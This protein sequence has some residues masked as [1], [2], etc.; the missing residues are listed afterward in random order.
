M[1]LLIDDLQNIDVATATKML[2]GWQ[3]ISTINGQRISGR[4]VET[5]GYHQDDSASHSFKHRTPRTEVM[6]GP[7]GH[8]YVYFTYGMHYCLNVVTGPEGRGEAVLIRAIEPIE[9]IDS[10]KK[11]RKKADLTTLTNGPAKLCQALSINTALTK[12]DLRKKPL[13]L[14]PDV[15]QKGESIVQ[16]TRIGISQ[17]KDALLRFYVK[18]SQF[19]SKYSD[20]K[21]K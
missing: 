13:L 1:S 3:I 20:E 18:D 15:L 5:E 21:S 10:M 14:I 12:H 11:N 8:A 16:T 6:F 2:L 19:V 4:I 7:A 17:A 9:G